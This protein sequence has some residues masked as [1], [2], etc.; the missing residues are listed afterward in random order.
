MNGINTW[1]AIIKQTDQGEF[2][3]RV[4][5]MPELFPISSFTLEEAKRKVRAR[6]LA[7]LNGQ[8]SQKPMRLITKLQ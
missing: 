8:T 6:L 5:E 4:E 2:I 7:A 3:S 1:T